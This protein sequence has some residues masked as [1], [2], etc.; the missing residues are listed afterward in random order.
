MSRAPASSIKRAQR[1]I[2]PLQLSLYH[3]ARDYPGGAQAIAAVFGRNPNTMAHKFNPHSERHILSPDEVEEALQATRDPRIVDSVIEAYGD[4]AWTDLRGVAE[5]FGQGH[6]NAASILKSIGDTLAR[7]S[8]L[9][10]TIAAHLANDGRIDADELAEQKLL[11]RRLHGALFL[12]E[13]S[14]EQE[15]EEV[16]RG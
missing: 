7:Q 6:D 11:L 8:L 1:Q 2:L 15:A 9:T 5:E 10:Q 3:A 13:R 16:E 14:L 4:A 12:L